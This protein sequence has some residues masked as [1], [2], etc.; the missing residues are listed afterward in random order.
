[1]G[2]NRTDFV[3]MLMLA[4]YAPEVI[5]AAYR[6]GDSVTNIITPMMSYFGLIMATVMK[7]KRCGR[8]Y[9]D[10]YDVAVFRLLFDCMDRLILHL[11]I[12]FGPAR[13]PRRAHF[14]SR[15]LNTI[16]KIPSENLF[17]FQTAFAFPSRQASPVP[18]LFSAAASVS[19]SR[20]ARFS[21]RGCSSG[22]WL[23]L[24]NTRATSV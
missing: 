14:V 8:G 17:C 20:R 1:M 6:I 7:Y 23:A 3:P 5:Q 4:G 9:S 24:P 12:C 10:F 16:N 2:G 19:A 22:F 13:R 11:G 21:N 18:S 15:T